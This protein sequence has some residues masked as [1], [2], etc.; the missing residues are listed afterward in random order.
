[1]T[2]SLLFCD[3]RGGAGVC[4]AYRYNG[5]TPAQI[6]NTFGVRGTG[7]NNQA[8]PRQG[9][10]WF[11][12]N[13]YAAAQNG[14]YVKDDPT[15]N[16]GG[17]TQ[18]HAYTG[19]RADGQG[20]AGLHV[21]NISDGT[22]LTTFYYTTSTNVWRWVKFDGT[23]WTTGSTGV[24]SGSSVTDFQEVT[25]Y[26]NVLHVFCRLTS[27][28]K[29]L[30]YDP[31]S[32][33]VAVVTN[34]FNANLV[35][36][37]C[38]FNDAL[39]CVWWN[40]AGTT[41]GL[42]TFS[43]GAWVHVAGSDVAHTITTTT[44]SEP[45]W[46][47]FTDGTYLYGLVAAA[48]NGWKCVQWDNTLGTPTDISTLV[49]P[50][51]LLSV[52]DGGAGTVDNRFG[53]FIPTLDQDSVP[54]TADIWLFQAANSNAGTPW[55]LWKWNGPGTLIG[56]A[57]V[58]D[59]VGGDVYHAI[60][61]G[62]VPGGEAIWSAGKFD[63]WITG[64]TPVPNAQRTTFRCSGDPGTA[65]K[66]VT[67][68]RDAENEPPLAIATLTGV[69]VISGSPAGSPSLGTNQVLNV[70]ADPTVEYYADWSLVTDGF[71]D[72]DR[73]QLKPVIAV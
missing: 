43:G 4:T 35:W 14:I 73:A 36:S 18:A 21:V 8:A 15:T 62:L 9:L 27:T 42:Y 57:G 6:G 59:D 25:V 65:D 10:R 45:K 46:G 1:M 20:H 34:P 52:L 16:S 7:N 48:G 22:W 44:S 58:A 3:S 5:A 13:L 63:I 26:R 55:N 17:W 47:L 56:N 67:F 2:A 23:T 12:S 31:A 41:A 64:K 39:Y 33:T 29:T 19:S 53:R 11:K 69:G 66:T 51:S 30:T 24:V 49:L 50:N 60:P 32:E 72:G 68:Y 28:E 61:S 54:T 38:V 70:D 37:A 40:T 71:V